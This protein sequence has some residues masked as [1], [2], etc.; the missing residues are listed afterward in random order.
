MAQFYAKIVGSRGDASRV[1]SKES[2]IWSHTR[3]WNAG[4]EVIGYVDDEGRDCFEVWTTGGSIAP[5]NGRRMIGTLIEGVGF[6][7]TA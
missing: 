7:F 5:S 6:A 2:G 4:V 1:G 3:G